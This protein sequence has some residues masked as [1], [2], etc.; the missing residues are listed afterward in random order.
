MANPAHF[1]LYLRLKS[2]HPAKYGG[3]RFVGPVG[4]GPVFTTSVAASGSPASIGC[5]QSWPHSA[6]RCS[7]GRQQFAEHSH[8]GTPGTSMF[9]S[10]SAAPPPRPGYPPP[11]GIRLAG[12]GQLGIGPERYSSNSN[13]AFVV[14]VA[15]NVRYDALTEFLFQHQSC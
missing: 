7:H 2:E 11:P 1:S 14:A 8:R 6:I 4:R 13:F 9:K 10:K 5:F 3:R 15:G 12:G